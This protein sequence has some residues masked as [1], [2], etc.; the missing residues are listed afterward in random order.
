MPDQS[1]AVQDDPMQLLVSLFGG[2]QVA[3]PPPLPTGVCV[4]VCVCVCVRAC[5]CVR[6]CVCVRARVCCVVALRCWCG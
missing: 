1:A 5:A 4:C 2:N 3:G 6:V